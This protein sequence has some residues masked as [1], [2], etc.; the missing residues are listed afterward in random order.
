MNAG[1]GRVEVPRSAKGGAAMGWNE[2]LSET[3]SVE[4]AVARPDQ[5]T[6]VDAAPNRSDLMTLETFM[7]P[8]LLQD[9]RVLERGICNGYA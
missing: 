2:G 5:A 3:I 4:D 1:I 7:F 8:P 9:F 6:H